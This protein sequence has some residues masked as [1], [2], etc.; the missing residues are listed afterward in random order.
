MR[1]TLSSRN[2]YVFFFFFIE[3]VLIF[4][5]NLQLVQQHEQSSVCWAPVLLCLKENDVIK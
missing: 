3:F 2:E 1:F 4:L 5:E